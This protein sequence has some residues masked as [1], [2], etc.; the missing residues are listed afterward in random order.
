MSSLNITFLWHMHQPYY[1]DSF[2]GQASMPWVRL[3]ACKAYTDM[4][5]MLAKHP[6]R[7]VINLVPSLLLQL[8]EYAGG[9][10]DLY[11]DIARKPAEDLT[12]DERIFLIENFFAANPDTMIRP[13]VRYRALL[14]KRRHGGWLPPRE[15]VDRFTDIE[16]RDLTV[17]F[18]LAWM[19]Y[20]AREEYPVIQE[21]IEKGWNFSEEDKNSVLDIGLELIKKV[22]P[23]LKRLVDENRVEL[24]TTPFFHPI[25]PLLIN[26]DIASRCMPWAKLPSP[27]FAYPEDALNQILAGREY[28]KNIFGREATG[29]WPS[30][31]SVCPEL[32]PML[33]KAGFEWFATD[34]DI[35]LESLRSKERTENIYHPWRVECGGAGVIGLFRD[36]A[37]ADRVGFDYPKMAE[38]NAAND[39][40]GR[41]K[42]IR[43]VTRAWAEPALVVI[44]LDGEN[45]W[46][47]YPNGGQEFLNIVYGALASDPDFT[48]VLPYEFL[49]QNPPKRV[50]T[51][52]HSGSWIRHDYSVW[53]GNHEENVAWE[54]LRNVRK[55]FGERICAFRPLPLANANI[56]QFFIGLLQEII[57]ALAWRE[58]YAA[59]GSDWFWW[60]GDEYT[61]DKDDE[62]D[63]IFRVHMAN[64]LR[65]IGDPVP[66]INDVPIARPHPVKPDVEPISFLHPTIDGRVTE[67]YE[68]N[69]G[70]RFTVRAVGSTMYTREIYLERIYYGFDAENLYIRLD[71]REAAWQDSLTEI[72]GKE[73]ALPVPELVCFEIRSNGKVARM[74]IPVHPGT[75]LPCVL[76]REDQ[77]EPENICPPTRAAAEKILEVCVPFKVLELKPGQAVEF[78]VM[79]EGLGREMDRYPKV[80]YL[81]FTVP[82]KDFERKMWSA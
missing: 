39:L 26:S 18:H 38:N 36:R 21:L 30:E 12:P 71:R 80:G 8:E 10:G 35:L 66:D 2:T 5:A 11:L 14:D 60:F 44:A 3:H 51:T 48:T 82:D 72:N 46:E 33:A 50:L 76:Y 28:F 61:S 62:F 81:T 16:L 4:P 79:L 68:W 37:L 45:A 49:R 75:D 64:V 70:G 74:E 6:V 29:V 55:Y 59:E 22:I 7:A 56:L 31:G 47:Y 17:W 20:T 19:G 32:A 73:E 57:L 78:S 54:R 9:A 53:I 65:F 23:R 40:L 27:A 41:L 15:I 34:E 25:L 67:Y 58:L 24:T 52:L 69:D 43:Q 77:G 42:A 13:H 63:R 1:R